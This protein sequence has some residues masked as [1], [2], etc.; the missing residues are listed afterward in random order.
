MATYVPGHAVAVVG[1]QR[2]LVLDP[3]PPGLD[4]TALGATPTGGLLEAVAGLASFALADW[5]GPRPVVAARTWSV[6]EGPASVELTGPTCT[7]GQPWWPVAAGVV[8]AGAVRATLAARPAHPVLRLSTGEEVEVR[9]SVVVGRRPRAVRPGATPQ[10]VPVPS[11]HGYVSGTHLEFTLTDGHLVVEDLSTNGTL[12][13][14][15]GQLAQRL[16]VRQPIVLVDGS[17]LELGD[18][19]SIEVAHAQA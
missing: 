12:L 8:L 6:T 16:P 9:G 1:P 15:H 7:A 2:L 11:P 3:P 4:V 18:G 14:R 17:R 13:H 10:L 5:S 19:V